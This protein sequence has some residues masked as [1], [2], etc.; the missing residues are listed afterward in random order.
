MEMATA[1]S[2]Y[3]HENSVN[4]LTCT[5]TVMSQSKP[6]FL[7]LFNVDRMFCAWTLDSYTYWGWVS[8]WL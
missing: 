7:W 1:L 6:H 2:A 8:S 5:I 3:N 4:G